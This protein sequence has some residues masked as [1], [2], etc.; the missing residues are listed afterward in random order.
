MKAFGPALTKNGASLSRLVCGQ[1]VGLDH[2]HPQE[3]LPQLLAAD[4]FLLHLLTT[5]SGRKNWAETSR[6]PVLP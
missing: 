6:M 4:R 3:Y 1:S 5:Q 2:L